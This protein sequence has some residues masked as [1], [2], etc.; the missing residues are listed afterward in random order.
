MTSPRSD[1]ASLIKFRNVCSRENV[2]L[3]RMLER[4]GSPT[5]ALA[6]SPDVWREVC[7]FAPEPERLGEEADR[8]A[9]AAARVLDALG[10]AVID[11]RQ[12]AYPESLRHLPQPPPVL[13]VRGV[14]ELLEGP[15]IAIVGARRH[16]VYGRDAAS[17]FTVGLVRAGYVILSGLAR[18]I[19]SV[20]HRTALEVGGHTV[21]VLGNGLDV[22][23]PPEHRDLIEAIAA[24]GCLVTEFPPGTP[25]RKYHFPQRNRLIAGLARAVLVV[26]A[27]ERSGALI[28]AH[29][30]LDEGK[31]VFAVPGPIHNPTSVGPNRLIQDGAGLAISVADILHAL[32]ARAG[33]PLPDALSSGLDVD[34][35]TRQLQREPDPG[36]S[37]LARRLWAALEAGAGDPE[38][39]AVQL[40]VAPG[41]LASALLELELAGLVR[42]LPG[43]RFERIR[44]CSPSPPRGPEG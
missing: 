42:K 2:P 20:A 18:G 15:A 21:A 29:Y 10:A 13:F 39:L 17:S 32:R 36:A 35:L 33:E 25:P 40:S 22:S 4:C 1:W 24:R 31:E 5:R 23:Y 28:T 38:S 26:E 19:D 11:V 7:R 8:R 9:E 14:H 6:A 16:S 44:R 27:A 12:A 43:P 41:P 34:E 37:Q 3:A 30:A